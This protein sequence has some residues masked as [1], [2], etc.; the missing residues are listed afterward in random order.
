MCRWLR[1]HNNGGFLSLSK[2]Y[3]GRW[4]R[5]INRLEAD[6]SEVSAERLFPG[7]DLQLALKDAWDPKGIMNPY[8][9]WPF[10]NF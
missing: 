8:K 1:S 10:T 3:D 2:E 9:A 4:M 5:W 7:R 6:G